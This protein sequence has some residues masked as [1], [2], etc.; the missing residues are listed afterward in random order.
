MSTE[1]LTCNHPLL[2]LTDVSRL[3]AEMVVSKYNPDAETPRVID[4]VTVELARRHRREASIAVHVTSRRRGA[5][6][7][8]MGRMSS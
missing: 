5:S 1:A 2:I 8:F 4:E 6:Q 7:F 3:T